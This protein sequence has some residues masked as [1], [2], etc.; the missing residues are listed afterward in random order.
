MKIFSGSGPNMLGIVNGLFSLIKY[1]FS[2]IWD[3]FFRGR[4]GNPNR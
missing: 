1:G 2:N 3:G 4:G